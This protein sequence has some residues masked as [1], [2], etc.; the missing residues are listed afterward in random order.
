YIPIKKSKAGKKFAFVRFLNV[1][2]FERLIENIGGFLV[3]INASSITSKEKMLSHVGTASWFLKLQ[4]ASDYF[5][6][7]ERLIRVNELEV[8]TP[9]F[10]NEFC[11][12]FSFDEDSVD[13]EETDHV[14]ESSCM[15]Q[16]SESQIKCNVSKQ[17]T[18][19]ADPFGI[20]DILNRNN[21]QEKV[22]KHVSSE[23]QTFPPG[24]TPTS[25]NDKA[26]DEFLNSHQPN[27]LLMFKRGTI[28][29]STRKYH[30]MNIT[31]LQLSLSSQTNSNLIPIPF[32]PYPIKKFTKKRDPGDYLKRTGQSIAEK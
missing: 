21:A 18:T 2:T 26:R 13:D 27:L 3:C 15:K 8:W 29:S 23:E 12:W 24:Y 7:E 30:Q 32:D 1:D 22:T 16:P 19:S 17:G 20:Y 10:N 6:T 28:H 14:L 5:V 4:P 25:V 31:H 9:N 11:E